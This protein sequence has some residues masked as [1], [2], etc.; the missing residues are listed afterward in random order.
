MLEPVCTNTVLSCPHTFAG[1]RKTSAAKVFS[2]S[3]DLDRT[4]LSQHTEFLA[5]LPNSKPMDFEA[6]R[7][8]LPDG[9]KADEANR[10]LPVRYSQTD[11]Q[12]TFP[13]RQSAL[14]SF[15]G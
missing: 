5:I 8:N 3:S 11:I 13:L 12:R 15:P 7:A 2:Q 10:S 9:G 4:Q 1:R 6:S 14:D